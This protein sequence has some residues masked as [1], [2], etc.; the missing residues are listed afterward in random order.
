MVSAAASSQPEF[1]P[2]RPFRV[3]VEPE[4]ET[5]RV[6]PVGELDLATVD[7]VGE[8]VRDLYEAGFD[9]V[10]LDLRKVSFID[11]TGLRLILALDGDARRYGTDFGLIAGRGSVQRVFEI[12]GLV[13]RLPFGR[14]GRAGSRT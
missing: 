13:E 9:R 5:V 1:E 4:R 12:C 8:Q 2:V 14:R 6:V 11:M 3:D 10:V 7:H